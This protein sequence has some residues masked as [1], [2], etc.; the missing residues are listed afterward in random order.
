VEDYLEARAG[1]LIRWPIKGRIS[2]V[3]LDIVA[4]HPNQK[5][6]EI[7]HAGVISV[8]LSWYQPLKRWHWWRTT[9]GNCSLTRFKEGGNRA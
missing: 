9:V 2:T 3:L 4:R 1:G 6:A 5:V 7:T 8:A